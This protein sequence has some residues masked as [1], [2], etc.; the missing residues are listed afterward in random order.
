[1]LYGLNDIA[2]NFFGICQKTDTLKSSEFWALRDVS[3][4]IERGE[5]LGIIGP[6]GSGKSTLLKILTGIIIPDMG[7]VEAKG[8]VGALI[9]LGAG[10]HPMLTGRENI[11]IYG[12]IL[13]MSTKQ[14]TKKFDEIVNFAELEDFIDSPVKHYSSGMYVRLGFAIA[15]HLEHDI[16]LIDEI[17]AVGDSG[18]QRK[19]QKKIKNFLNN[20]GC[21]IL[22]THNIIHVHSMTSK[23]MV[24]E[25]GR[26]VF[27]GD[28][29]RAGEIYYQVTSKR[30]QNSKVSPQPSSL[31]E[32]R[33]GSGDAQL[34]DIQ[35]KSKCD[36]NPEEEKN[37]CIL[38]AGKP[39][40]ITLKILA[41]TDL[42]H[43]NVGVGLWEQTGLPLLSMNTQGVNQEI[44]E[45]LKDEETL[46][47]FEFIC[48][49]SSGQYRISAGI[50][51]TKD[52]EF[53]D[54][55]LNWKQLIVIDEGYTYG[56]IKVPYSINWERKQYN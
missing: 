17:L 31:T 26:P 22:V 40:I 14:I 25:N 6:N 4:N 7:R 55:R 30:M 13:G 28:T 5:C 43:L 20:G 27:H 46:I 36:D 15:S 12:S 38:I 51:S 45:L 39:S 2:L 53:C 21:A 54:R 48:P 24:L 23:C 50:Y 44:T 32:M 33:Y 56:L 8:R 34:I 47:K 1:M 19:C 52:K 37:N 3:F 18:F 41:H 10:F 16:L 11:Y 49:L 35:V 29:N 9:E 42:K